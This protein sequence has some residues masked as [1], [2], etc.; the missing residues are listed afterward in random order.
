MY[1]L[2][3]SGSLWLDLKHIYLLVCDSRMEEKKCLPEK[4]S[5][6]ADD[7][8]IY[9]QGWGKEAMLLSHG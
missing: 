8:K 7:L 1:T 3:A 5:S 2:V 9:L 6:Y 4:A